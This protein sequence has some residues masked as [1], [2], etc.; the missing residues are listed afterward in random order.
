MLLSKTGNHSSRPP[1]SPPD[2]P[3][4]TGGCPKLTK[5]VGERLG[6][7]DAFGPEG[8]D[9]GYRLGSLVRHRRPRFADGRNDFLC[10][11]QRDGIVR[12]GG[13]LPKQG[14][15]ALNAAS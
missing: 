10:G 11:D 5:Q 3:I 14:G 8:R 7:R 1:T 12:A 2:I 15:L 6:G 4:P 9:H 13:P